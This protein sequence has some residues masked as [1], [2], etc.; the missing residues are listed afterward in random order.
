MLEITET[1]HCMQIVITSKQ[2]PRKNSKV[3]YYKV[4]K[5]LENEWPKLE[6]P[7]FES[8]TMANLPYWPCGS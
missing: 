4:D 5:V 1:V 6:T 3:N 7:V 8:S 2:V